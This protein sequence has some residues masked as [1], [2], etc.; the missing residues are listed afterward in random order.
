MIKIFFKSL[1]KFAFS[2]DTIALDNITEQQY[3]DI[4]IKGRTKEQIT[5]TYKKA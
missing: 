5:E 3:L 2:K 1:W 4:F